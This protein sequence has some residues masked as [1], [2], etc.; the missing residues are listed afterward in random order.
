MD[1]ELLIAKYIS[2]TLSTEEQTMFERLLD[3]DKAFKDEVKFQES[4]KLAA[5]AKGHQ[6]LK[7]R[8]QA[9]EKEI[10]S[11]KNRSVW[12]LAA[13]SILVLVT[14]VF[15]FFN[16]NVSSDELYANYYEPAKNIVHPIVRDIKEKDT[17]TNAFIAYQKKDYKTA[18]QLFS[19]IY[20]S[21]NESEFLFYEA[22]SLLEINN[23]DDAIIR[24]ESH[25]NYTD[26][27]SPK[28]NWYL[29]LAH[30][31]NN[32]ITEVKSILNDIIIDK[33]AF[34]F[35]EAKALLKKI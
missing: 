16:M 31:K 34:K 32:N 28:T 6:Q 3:T 15:Y 27:L 7:S 9:L 26:A 20:V 1:K 14:C 21:T 12:W 30:L 4:V 33:S 25:K 35:K 5:T 2:K 13:A 11:T 29:A 8:F 24:L 19:A 10:V 18:Q 17:K 22:I 23:I